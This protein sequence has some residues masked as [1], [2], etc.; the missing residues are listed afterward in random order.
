MKDGIILL[1]RSGGSIGPWPDHPFK[2]IQAALS[3]DPWEMQQGEL[4]IN[5]DVPLGKGCYGEVFKGTLTGRRQRFG[6]RRG[7]RAP[8]YSLTNTVAIKRLQSTYRL[9]AAHSYT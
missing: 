9:H 7:A 4:S 8:R 3:L 5:E 6:S 1:N 2:S